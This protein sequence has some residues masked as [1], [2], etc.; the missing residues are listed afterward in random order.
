MPAFNFKGRF[1]GA[2]AGG[3]KR[4]TIRAKRKNRPRVGQTAYCYYGMRGKGCRLLGEWRITAVCDI[5]I[6]QL[7]VRIDG[8]ELLDSEL[9]GLARDD[10]F[11]D[12]AEMLN[13]FRAAHGLPFRGDL[14]MWGYNPLNP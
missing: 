14:I 9:D 3:E 10:G 12:I 13:W 2:V 6:E 4:Q 1:A 11:A 5:T 7:S 8:E